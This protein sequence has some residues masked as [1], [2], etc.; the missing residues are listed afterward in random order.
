MKKFFITALAVASLTFSNNVKAQQGFSL[1]VKATPQ[2]SFLQNED[3]NDNNSINRKATFNANFGIGAG[4]SFTRNVGVGLD[5]LY[6]LQGQRRDVSGVE[7]N[8][9]VNYLKVPVYFTYNTDASKPVS[10]IAKVGPQLSIVTD[11]KL[12]DKDGDDIVGNTKDRYQSAAFGA[13]AG[14]G[15]QFKLNKNLFLSTAARFDYD[16]TNAE[17]DSYPSFPAGR[18]NTYN[19]TTGLEVGLKY[20]LK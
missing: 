16:F 12:A 18:P 9:K 5:V 19:M 6:S 11:A 15:V 8:E 4:Y 1:S 17:D 3:D 10:F 2:F 20:M 7:T 14:A 13:V